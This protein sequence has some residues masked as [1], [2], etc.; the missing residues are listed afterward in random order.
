MRPIYELLRILQD[1]M[2]SADL[3]QLVQLSYLAIRQ[4]D[5]IQD[6]RVYCFREMVARHSRE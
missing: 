1:R 5:L 2:K 4:I 3:F 6:V